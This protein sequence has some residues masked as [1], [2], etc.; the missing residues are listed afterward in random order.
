MVERVEWAIHGRRR[1]R[2]REAWE[3]PAGL[4]AKL[5]LTRPEL[6]PS[7]RAEAVEGL[8][9]WLRICQLSNL[10]WCVAMPSRVVDDAWHELILFTRRT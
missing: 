7:A 2:F 4:D 8:R 10:R 5:A 6:S 9:D 1:R 3:P